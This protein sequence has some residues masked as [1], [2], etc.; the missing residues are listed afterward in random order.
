VGRREIGVAIDALCTKVF[1]QN[2]ELFILH[3]YFSRRTDLCSGFRR[4]PRFPENAVA[5]QF[6]ITPGQIAL[7]IGVQVAGPGNPAIAFEDGGDELDVG[8]QPPSASE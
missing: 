7:L 2:I 3:D 8:A 4:V 1:D 5:Y 6:H